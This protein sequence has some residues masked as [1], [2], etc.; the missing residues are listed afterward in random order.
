[1]RPKEKKA[2]FALCM[3]IF[4]GGALVAFI[5]AADEQSVLSSGL[6]AADKISLQQLIAHAPGS[7]KH[8]ELANFY[9][10]RRYILSQRRE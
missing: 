1:M 7:N 3:L 9:F 8:I 10:G 2:A 6:P 4:F 5:I